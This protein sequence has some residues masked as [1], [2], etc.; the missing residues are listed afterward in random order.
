VALGLTLDALS[1]RATVLTVSD[2][3]AQMVLG[4]QGL[5]FSVDRRRAESIPFR[6]M[7]LPEASSPPANALD[8]ALTKLASWYGATAADFVALQME[9]PRAAPR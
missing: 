5:R 8:A 1:R 9:Y 6:E 7:R 4:R 2:G 3:S